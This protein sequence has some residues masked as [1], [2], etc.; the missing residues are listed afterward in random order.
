MNILTS[1][2]LAPGV[3]LLV[4]CDVN[5]HHVGP[6][7]HSNVHVDMGKFENARLELKMGAGELRLEGGS[8][9]LMEG[10]FTYNV[11]TWKPLFNARTTGLRADVRVDQTGGASFGDA[12]NTW[13]M[14]INDN[15][16]WDVITHLGAGEAHMELGS[17]ML[18][19]IEVHMGV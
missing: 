6:L 16:P 7:E 2:L 14:K 5:A 10:D 15:V 17:A 4:G 13:E 12:Q 3:V 11:P 1:L 9:K 19:K 18:R 8:A